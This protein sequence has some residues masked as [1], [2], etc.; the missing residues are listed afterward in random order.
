VSGRVGAAATL[1]RRTRITNDGRDDLAAVAGNRL[2]T[3]DYCSGRAS[4]LL[5]PTAR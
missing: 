2:R 1:R 5:T 3:D 4:S